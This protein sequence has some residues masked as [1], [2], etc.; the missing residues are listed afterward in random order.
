MNPVTFNDRLAEALDKSDRADYPLFDGW[1]TAPLFDVE[2]P[3]AEALELADASMADW[4]KSPDG[5]PL[6]KDPWPFPVMRA[7]LSVERTEGDP[8]KIWVGEL[9]EMKRIHMVAAQGSKTALIVFHTTDDIGK[10]TV[11]AYTLGNEGEMRFEGVHHRKMGWLTPGQ[12]HQALDA[13]DPGNPISAEKFKRDTGRVLAST[14]I[15]FAA[16]LR[17]AMSP[18]NHVVSVSPDKQG[19]SVQWRAART[20][21]TLITHGHPANR[22]EVQHGAAV[23]PDKEGELRRMAHNRRAHFR[24]LKAARFTYARGKTVLVRATWVGPKEWREAGG[25]QIY[26][27]LEPVEP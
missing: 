19:K 10:H 25:K 4:T 13:S 22:R 8:K 1:K 3:E 20:H 27:I 24:T 11:F 17:S 15:L 5:T 9:R 2:L 14:M 7:S 18:Q 16:F 26:R 6:F 23:A 12:F 21:Y